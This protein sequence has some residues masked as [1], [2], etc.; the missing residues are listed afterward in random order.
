M[1]VVKLLP[2]CFLILLSSCATAPEIQTVQTTEKRVALVI[3]N[4][5]YINLEKK[6]QL[7]KA[8]Q[9]ARDM[10]DKLR[11]LGFR[12]YYGENLSLSDMKKQLN[13]FTAELDKNTLSFVYYS[14]HGASDSKGLNYLIPSDFNGKEGLAVDEIVFQHMKEKGSIKNIIVLDMCRSN[15]VSIGGSVKGLAK[16]DVAIDSPYNLGKKYDTDGVLIAYATDPNNFAYEDDELRN[17]RYTHFLLQHIGDKTLS[18]SELFGKIIGE[19]ME[20]SKE[21]SI[22]NRDKQIQIPWNSSSLK[23][24]DIFLAKMLMGSEMGSRP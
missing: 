2:F 18:V 8:V 9:D 21:A 3:G 12:V 23:G 4:N 19:V 22:K 20:A 15:G 10:R 5:H 6:H 16:G 11:K 1:K 24:Y 13:N 14:G 17:S 7:K